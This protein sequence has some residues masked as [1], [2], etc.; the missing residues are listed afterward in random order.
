MLKMSRHILVTICV[1]AASTFAL[2]AQDYQSSI[3]KWDEGPLT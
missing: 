3:R 2:K 1:L